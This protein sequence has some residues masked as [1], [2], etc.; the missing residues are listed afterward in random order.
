MTYTLEEWGILAAED[1]ES[2]YI[3]RPMIFNYRLVK[4]PRSDISYCTAGFCYFGRGEV[5]LL[6][7]TAAAK[8][9]AVEGG[10]E[11]RH[12]NKNVETGEVRQPGLETSPWPTARPGV[13]ESRPLPNN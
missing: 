12:W 6:R 5:T 8:L 11:P 10:D 1:S 3:I 2:Y 13:T 7:A 4:V 9:W